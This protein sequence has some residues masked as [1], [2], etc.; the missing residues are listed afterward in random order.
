MALFKADRFAS[1]PPAEAA[2]QPIKA[3]AMGGAMDP[4]KN[5]S[6]GC[7]LEAGQALTMQARQA[8]ALRVVQGRL[9]VTFSNAAQDSRVRA[10]DHFL[11]PGDSL[12]LAAGETVVME[13]WAVGQ[14]A[15][16]WV[17]WQPAPVP[18]L[19]PVLRCAGA[20]SCD[21]AFAFPQ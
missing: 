4:I 7:R 9:W 5:P 20:S 14:A 21:P 8:G 6:G 16:A 10:G 3:A 19:M 12:A 13:S 11:L 15:P 1:P 17:C 2:G 18:S